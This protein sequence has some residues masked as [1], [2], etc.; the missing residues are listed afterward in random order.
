MATGNTALLGLALPV[1]GE[2]DGTWGDVVNASITSL[3]DS[4]I[5]GTTTLSTDADVTLTTTSLAANQARQAVILWTA[6][7]GA[8]TRNITAPAQSK[9][10]IVIN[11]GTGSIVLRGVGPTTGITILA[12]E[13]CM[14]AW[15]GSD[16]V[17]IGT[18]ASSVTYTPAGATAVPSNVQ[19]KLRE[20]IS[21]K[22]F[23]AVG[24]GTTNDTTAIQNAITYCTSDVNNPKT[25]FFPE[26]DYRI[27]AGFTQITCKNFVMYGAGRGVEYYDVGV[28]NQGASR[29]VYDGTNS[30][31][32]WIFDYSAARGCQ[33]SQLSILC[34][35]K[36]NAIRATLSSNLLFEKLGIYEAYTGIYFIAS[37]FSSVI[38]N[39]VSFDH[40]T[41]H[42]VF[43][44]TAH[45]TKISNCSF[46]SLNT[47]SGGTTTPASVITLGSTESMSM[48]TISG[49]NFDVWRVPV[50]ILAKDVYGLLITGNYFEPRDATMTRM[51]QLGDQ[52]ADVFCQGV[53][54]SGNKLYGT[55]YTGD[56]VRIEKARGVNIDGNVFNSMTDA[57][58]CADTGVSV[59]KF[60]EG[61]FISANRFGTSITGYGLT[62]D[63]A[64]CTN[65]VM[66]GNTGTADYDPAQVGSNLYFA[67]EQFTPVL[68]FGGNSVGVTYTTQV[69][70]YKKIGSRVFFQI[71]LIVTSKGSST[72]N[73][74]ITGLPFTSTSA[75][76][77]AV[78][79][80]FISGFVGL[81]GAPVANIN[82]S[83]TDIALGQTSATGRSLITDTSFGS[84]SFTMNVTGFYE[85]E[86]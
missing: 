13:K 48:V 52:T 20:T 49:C 70:L 47:S 1:E 77:Q 7:N 51:I 81:T 85:I 27:T 23:G 36:C 15:N 30:S 2:L 86:M 65:I 82:T 68:A 62:F 29:I 59:N 25:L 44:E 63:N 33:I 57:I 3:V 17:K 12:G 14:A 39:V 55:A 46:A 72:G 24:D 78:P 18:A 22:D 53:A 41:D 9:P 45:S 35:G 60:A 58:N 56:G 31:S 50:N 83:A 64:A 42:I 37:C 80:Q 34:E 10:Y 16:F 26:G 40:A 28:N 32:T 69:G 74:T 8:T 4:A 73:A 11:A 61:V 84:G 38:D 54:I 6:S 19:T 79:V 5:A 66:L 67:E 71:R 75:I 76:P 21:V 43:G